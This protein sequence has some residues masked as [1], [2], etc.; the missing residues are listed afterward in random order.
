[1]A[2]PLINASTLKTQDG[3]EFIAFFDLQRKIANE[4]EASHFLMS[5]L[6]ISPKPTV[7]IYWDEHNDQQCLA[8]PPLLEHAIAAFRPNDFAHHFPSL[9]APDA[10]LN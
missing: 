3:K 6:L 8:N 7:L 10:T 2:K 9:T 4:D 5:A 1:M